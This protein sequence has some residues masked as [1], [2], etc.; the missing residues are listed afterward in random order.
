MRRLL[1]GLAALLVVAIPPTARAGYYTVTDMGFLGTNATIPNAINDSGQVV[2]DTYTMGS[3]G[4]PTNFKAFLYSGGVMT[5]LGTL[6]G[7]GAASAASINASGQVVGSAVAADGLSHPFLYSGGKMTDLGLFPGGT[8]SY[9]SG[10]NASGQIVGSSFTQYDNGR[11]FL[12]NK[13][14]TTDLGPWYWTRG[15]NASGQVVGTAFTNGNPHAYLYSK[16]QMIDLGTLNGGNFSYAY[17]LNDSGQVAGHSM[18]RYG[19]D[20]GFLFSNG[21]MTDLGSLGGPEI[22]AYGINNAGQ[23]VGSSETAS[24]VNHAYVYANGKMQDLNTLLVGGGGWTLD[25]AWAINNKGQIVTTGSRPGDL[26]IHGLLL[27]PTSAPEPGGL[28]LLALGTLGL[29]ARAWLRRR[30]RPGP[31]SAAWV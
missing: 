10:I 20:R 26:N 30:P 28:T 27:T 23:V 25:V 11:A 9:A 1:C 7:G 14:Q 31:F 5:G 21:Q 22:R 13:G 19:N 15:V 18:D 12:L 4:P 3:G 8:Q 24:W 2:G 16:G 17:A 29:A 6:P